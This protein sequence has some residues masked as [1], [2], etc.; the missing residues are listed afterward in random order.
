[1]KNTTK[2]NLVVTESLKLSIK[3]LFDSKP[4]QIDSKPI[5]KEGVKRTPREWVNEL[6]DNH[7]KVLDK[8]YA[9][10]I[11]V[12]EWK[13]VETRFRSAIR[14]DL[15]KKITKDESSFI[16]NQTID[17]YREI[18]YSYNVTE[19]LPRIYERLLTVMLY[20]KNR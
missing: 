3:A 14:R 15:Q 6:I 11:S 1:M 7:A 4:R 8:F 13:A 18:K 20:G 9:R 2:N 10:E 12:K 16:F 17:A 19:E 5:K